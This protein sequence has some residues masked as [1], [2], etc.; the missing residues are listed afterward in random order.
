[1][2]GHVHSLE[3]FGSADGP[4]VRYLIFLSG[5]PMRCAYCHNPDTWNV[6]AGE[7]MSADEILDKAENYRAYWGEAGGITVSGGEPLLQ[8][9]F[10]VELL[11]SAKERAMNT[12]IDSSLA[13]FTREEPYFSKFKA[14]L[15]VCDLI[16]ADIKHIDP[17]IHKKL[18][19]RSNENILD[20]FSYLNEVDQPIWIRHVLVEGYTDDNESLKKTAEFISKLKNVERVEVLPYHTLGTFKYDE[21]GINYPLADCKPPTPERVAK[22]QKILEGAI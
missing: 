21:L 7:L 10:L 22:A 18:T 4:G 9:D 13:T 5:C 16:L 20:C 12:C 2:Q 17:V 6:S 14:M 8:I 3:S 15:E 1:M 11:R 19:G